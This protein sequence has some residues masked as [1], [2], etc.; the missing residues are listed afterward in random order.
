MM[1]ENGI[2]TDKDLLRRMMGM[3]E[4]PVVLRVSNEPG[5][6]GLKEQTVKEAG[7]GSDA[8]D[9]ASK[10]G[11]QVSIA[12]PFDAKA[13]M[14]IACNAGLACAKIKTDCE[15]KDSFACMKSAHCCK[16]NIKADRD[17]RIQ[18]DFA[19]AA[20][21][22]RQEE[23]EKQLR[24]KRDELNKREE[25]IAAMAATSKEKD[26][27]EALVKEKE[28]E[29]ISKRAELTDVINANMKKKE[30]LKEWRL[31]E[32]KKVADREAALNAEEASL[33][34]KQVELEQIKAKINDV[35]MKRREKVET[36][37][38]TRANQIADTERQLDNKLDMLK[39][40]TRDALGAKD[41]AEQAFNT[42]LPPPEKTEEKEKA[43]KEK[44]A[45]APKGPA[46]KPQVRVMVEPIQDQRKGEGQSVIDYSVTPG[47]DK[48]AVTKHTVR[49][50]TTQSYPEALIK[51]EAGK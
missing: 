2:L 7:D 11:V 4:K 24:K 26:K 15:A 39:A 9:E 32:Y 34:T 25:N 20:A 48:D 22:E 37:I 45:A 49:I 8:D 23:E 27:L 46:P 18:E 17:K 33:R 1:M 14:G 51:D 36:I 44:A 42:P 29:V 43:D 16:S 40:E 31:G 10:S 41:M 21:K 30:A 12:H 13:P 35:L 6:D 19:R 3:K 5:T 28:A 47:S 50:K 38:N